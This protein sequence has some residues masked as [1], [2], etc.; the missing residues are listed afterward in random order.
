[1]SIISPDA[2]EM[3]LNADDDTSA[4]IFDDTAANGDVT[5]NYYDALL[6]SADICFH[7]RRALH[8]YERCF[9]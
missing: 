9:D 1:M 3:R 2:N 5:D 7:Y 4:S 6:A 8:H